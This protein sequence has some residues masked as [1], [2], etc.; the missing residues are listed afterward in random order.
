MKK[1]IDKFL[2]NDTA[3][4]FF[5]KK[6]FFSFECFTLKTNT[7]KDPQSCKKVL[8]NSYLPV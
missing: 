4:M 2:K 7:Q 1:G 8:D 6:T 3:T 5:L